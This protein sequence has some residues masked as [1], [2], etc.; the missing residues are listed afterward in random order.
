MT[1]PLGGLDAA[2]RWRPGPGALRSIPF[3]VYIAFL[4]LGPRLAPLLEDARWLY[5]VQAGLAALALAVLYRRYGELR[6]PPAAGAGGWLLSCLAGVAVFILWINLDLPWA[7]LGEGRGFDPRD[8]D[9]AI[10]WPLAVVRIAGAALVVPVM[11]ELFWRS[12]I[13]RWID[14]P[15]FLGAPARNSLRALA[16]ASLLFGFEH[17]LWFAGI[18]AGLAYGGLYR[19]RGNL[20]MPILAHAITNFLLGAW[21]LATGNWSF[22]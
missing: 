17:S 11:E 4:M 1:A 20:W 2:G 6:H 18:L 5:A 19:L 12:F 22:W 8:G 13:Q 10:E 14:R 21:V 9:G 7:T 15:D 16:L 3:A